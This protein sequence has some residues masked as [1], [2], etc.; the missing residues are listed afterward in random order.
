MTSK[1]TRQF[2]SGVTNPKGNLGDYQHA[3]RL[4]VDGDLRLSPKVKFLYYVVFTINKKALS[5]FAIDKFQNEV[6]MLVKRADLP[7]FTITTET[8]NQYNRKRVVQNKIDY[9]PLTIT[10][11]DDSAGVTTKMWENYYK[12]YYADPSTAKNSIG[13]YYQTATRRSDYVKGPY[14]FDNG[15]KVR[16]F[17]KI[18][19]YQ[20]SK[21]EWTGFTL[22]NP[23]VS[24]WSHDSMDH[25]VSQPVE[26]SMTVNYETIYYS[27]G[28]VSQGNPPGF[29]VEHYDTLPSPISLPG[30]GT[31]SL[32]GAGGVLAGISSVL[33]DIGSMA[34]D[35][36][37]ITL[38][39]VLS[40]A[41]TAVNTYK[42]AS[43]LSSAGVAQELTTAAVRGLNATVANI[44]FPVND[45]SSNNTTVA[46]PVNL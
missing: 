6:N 40:T 45:A 5:D 18:T 46:A 39:N 44:R 20:M 12:Y 17:D 35:T 4:F 16:F 15:S 31:R 43:A 26:S 1:A 7:K 38:G 30:G 24:S 2:V 19:I 41:I 37:N 32:L 10:F 29:G 27:T 3:A 14:G 25:S 28:K 21:K 33:G 13:S 11:H 36:S 8:L 42:N 9:Q 34:S 23:L 22:V